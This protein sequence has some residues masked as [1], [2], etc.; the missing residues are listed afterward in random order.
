[1]ASGSQQLAM[2]DRQCS[3][4]NKG[5]LWFGAQGDLGWPPYTWDHCLA[6]Q[7]GGRAC[8][9]CKRHH[10]HAQDDYQAKKPA[11]EQHLR[12]IGFDATLI[13]ASGGRTLNAKPV[14]TERRA[15][16]LTHAQA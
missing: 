14:Y 4:V 2:S 9:A 15:T 7:H 16:L 10:Q 5:P 12:C 11:E 1:M 6:G 3:G 13:S 8:S